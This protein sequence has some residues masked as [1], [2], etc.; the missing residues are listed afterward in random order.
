MTNLNIQKSIPPTLTGVMLV[1]A[2]LSSSSVISQSNHLS[3]KDSSEIFPKTHY[4]DLSKTPET[5]SAV[6]YATNHGEALLDDLM[7][8]FFEKLSYE[9][10][11]LDPEFAKILSDNILEL[12]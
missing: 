9:S 6:S 12:F 11:P 2:F 5:F 3:F 8:D 7:M 10:K 4:V 1:T